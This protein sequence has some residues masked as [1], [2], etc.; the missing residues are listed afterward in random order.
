MVIFMRTLTIILFFISFNSFAQQSYI[1]VSKKDLVKRL[2]ENKIT[3]KDTTSSNVNWMQFSDQGKI[4]T[5]Y[6][7]KDSVNYFTVF[8]KLEMINKTIES[9]NAQF[10]RQDRYRWI[11]DSHPKH[12]LIV[13]IKKYSDGFI[14]II[15]KAK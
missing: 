1:G 10:E 15:S 4:V 7:N 11:D 6:L 13:E 5:T 3:Y 12:M 2:K 9:Y 8:S 14:S